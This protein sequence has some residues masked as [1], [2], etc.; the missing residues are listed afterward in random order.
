MTITSESL[1]NTVGDLHILYRLRIQGIPRR[2]P[3]IIQFNWRSPPYGWIKANTDDVA[4][5]FFKIM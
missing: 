5:R 2:S 1:Q 4:Y 3:W